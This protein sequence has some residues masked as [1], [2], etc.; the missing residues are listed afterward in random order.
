MVCSQEEKMYAIREVSELTGVK[1]VTLRAWQRRYNLIQPKRTEK[2]HRLYREQDLN[3][4]REVQGWLAKGVSIGKVKDLL[5]RESVPAY[6]TRQQPLE[7]VELMLQALAQL[8]RGRSESLLASVLKDYPFDIVTEQFVAP[9]FDA[10]ERVKGALR[11]LQYG[12]FQTCLVTR[13]MLIVDAEN[14]A[15]SKGKCLLL[16]Y[17]QTRAAESWIQAVR[18][19]SQG[20]HITMIDGVDDLAGLIEHDVVHRYERVHVFSNN[21]LPVKQCEVLQTLREQYPDKFD[22]SQVIEKL[23]PTIT[24]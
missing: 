22:Y 11:S 4:I 3:T 6:S 9:I 5:G 18:L 20:Y 15:A 17:E 1:P 14:K 13:L 19:C 24:G 10:L 23:H 12:L 7:E 16:C 8:N 2:G 21:A